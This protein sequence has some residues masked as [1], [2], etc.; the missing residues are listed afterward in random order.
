[1]R[2]FEIV[3]TGRTLPGFETDGAA[4]A[5]ASTLRVPQDKA[6]ELLAGRET[7]VKRGVTED[8]VPPYV[9][10]LRKCGAEVRTRE[11]AP[12]TTKCPACGTEQSLLR[13]LCASCGADMKRVAAAQEA[14]KNPPRPAAVTAFSPPKASVAPVEHEPPSYRRS[15]L[16]ELLLFLFVTPYWGWKVMTD[17][18]R[19][20]IANA[21]GAIVLVAS[22]VQIFLLVNEYRKYGWMG[23]YAPVHD[24]VEAAAAAR[25]QV[26]EFVIAHRRL[27]E[28][29]EIRV[30]ALPASVEKIDVGPRGR[31]RVLLA[32]DVALGPG[33][34]I[35]LTPYMDAK[36]GMGWECHTAGINTLV[37]KDCAKE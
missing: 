4:A 18:E 26:N 24:A 35:V 20:K 16:K 7:V 17:R 27:P 33:G 6:R 13:N 2:T 28:R 34:S 5:L 31:V 21:F 22:S 23:E 1:M 30:G 37:A 29:G 36:G 12:T 10:A 11:P 14:A 32:A 15:F 9:A 3:L 8:Q 19:G 25:D